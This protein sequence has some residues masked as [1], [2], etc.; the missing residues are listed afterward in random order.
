MA[1]ALQKQGV[2]FVILE[3]AD[4]VGGTWRDNTYP[5]CACD[6]PSHLYSFSFEPKAD[7][8]H[9]FSYWD[10]ILG[11]LKGSPTST[12]C[13]ATSSS[14]RSSIAATGTTTNAAGTCSPPTGVN[15]SRS[16]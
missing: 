8:K 16:S 10:E 9:L 5:G 3:K 2:D 6:I 4:D 13:A 7:W 12:A 15:T 11:Y 1:I 14:I